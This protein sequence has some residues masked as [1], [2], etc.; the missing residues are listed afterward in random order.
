MHAEQQVKLMQKHG[1]MKTGDDADISAPAMDFFVA[2]GRRLTRV[3]T[4]GPPQILLKSAD[5]KAQTAATADKFV[6]KFDSL[7]QLASVHGS[8]NARV[9][10]KEQTPNSCS[11]D[12]RVTTSDSI[13]ASFHPGRGI[14]A[15]LQEGHFSYS[16]GTQKAFAARARYTPA[17]QILILDGAPRIVDA[18]MTTTAR[19]VRL[20]RSTGDGFAEGDVKSTYSDLKP[21]VGGGLLASSD[22]VHVTAHSMTAA[23]A[24]PATATYT[25][26]ARLWQNANVVDAPTLQFQKDQRTIIADSGPDGKVSTVLVGTD[27]NGKA[28][29]VSITSRRLTYQD[30]QRKAHFEGGVQLRS[31]DLNIAADHMDV[32]VAKSPGANPSSSKGLETHPSGNAG[33]AKLEKIVASGSVLITE[34]KRRAS[35]EQLTYTASDDRFVLSGGTPSIFDAE[36]GKITGVSLTLFRRDDRVVVEGDSSSPAVTQTRVVR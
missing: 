9:V 12:D 1:A 32:F 16:A 5:G 14:E 3:E 22:P 7:G 8:A 27:K 28:A 24:S 31:S 33:P 11:E 18:G 34:P 10:T 21:Q 15:L 26:V 4:V 6:A 29:P 35:G 13:D 30:S 23:H 25:G 17:D 20:N 19:M 2:E 36:R